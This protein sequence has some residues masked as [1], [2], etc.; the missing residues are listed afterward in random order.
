MGKLFARIQEAV[1][2]E[3]FLVSWHADEQCEERGVTPWQLAA[4]MTDAELERE[5]P[6]SKPHPSIVVREELS[7]GSVLLRQSGRGLKRVNVPSW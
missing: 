2:D 6:R 7:D 1:A 3:R 4:G 5:R